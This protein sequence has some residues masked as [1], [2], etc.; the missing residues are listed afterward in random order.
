MVLETT[1]SS[2]VYNVLSLGTNP[3]IFYE[4]QKELS[5]DQDELKEIISDKK[6]GQELVQKLFRILFKPAIIE[7]F[8]N[9]PIPN[10]FTREGIVDFFVEQTV[11]Q[12]EKELDKLDQTLKNNIILKFL[13]LFFDIAK[14]IDNKDKKVK[15]EKLPTLLIK[16]KNL[17]KKIIITNIQSASNTRKQL[18]GVFLCSDFPSKFV[19]SISKMCNVLITYNYYLLAEGEKFLE[20]SIRILQQ[21]K[22]FKEGRWEQ[23]FNMDNKKVLE[24]Q[25]DLYKNL[26]ELTVFIELWHAP[27]MEALLDSN[28]E[29]VFSYKELNKEFFEQ[30]ILIIEETAN[31][32]HEIILDSLYQQQ[33]SIP[34][35][36]EKDQELTEKEKKFLSELLLF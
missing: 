36:L 23:F 29:K 19:T 31:E 30:K 18:Q 21:G 9:I 5:V 13:K 14:E 33:L 6:S 35:T 24:L 8:K 28:K 22:D 3:G 7:L 10:R 26:M 15:Q 2:M 20:E 16:L 12:L 34:Y 25:F 4:A 17:Y 27:T 11:I 1:Q 32:L